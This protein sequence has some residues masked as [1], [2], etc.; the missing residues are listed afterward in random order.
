MQ[1][2]QLQ[3]QTFAGFS[4]SDEFEFTLP[5]LIPQFDIDMDK[6]LDYAKAYRS[7]FIAFERRKLEAERLKQRIF[8]LTE[9]AIDE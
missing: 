6:A 5:E 7:D 8:I 4:D 2:A 3:L 1:T 9:S